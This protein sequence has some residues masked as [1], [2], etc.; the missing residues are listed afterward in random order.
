M[1]SGQKLR[2]NL[3][4]PVRIPDQYLISKIIIGLGPDWNLLDLAEETGSTILV[5][6]GI[7]ETEKLLANFQRPCMF[8]FVI[9]FARSMTINPI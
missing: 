7:H 5:A 2:Q 3:K 9:P 8:Y 1:K 6:K 4:K